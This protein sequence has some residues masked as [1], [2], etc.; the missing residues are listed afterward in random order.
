MLASG[1]TYPFVAELLKGL[2][3]DMAGK[4]F[5][6]DDREPT[7]SRISL[8]SGV[9]RKDVRRLRQAD[10]GRDDAMPDSVSFGAQLVA[11][12]VG[13]TRFQDGEGRPL[14]LARWRADGGEP[15]FE[16]L[17]ASHSKD[18]RARV[19]L[20]EWLRLGI[21]GIDDEDRIVLNSDAFIPTEGLEEKLY[22]YSH[23][24]HDHAA[25]ATDNLLGI[26][27]PRLERSVYYDE[28]SAAS[29]EDLD[30]QAR[31]LGMKMLKALNRSAMDLEARDAKS[32]AEPHRFT[33]GIY[34][35]SE[36]AKKE[37][38]P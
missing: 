31:Q 6:L 18:I 28:L 23:N 19:V 1:I 14:P 27:Q 12:W 17:V 2:F 7:D 4:E 37:P 34:F 24:L 36:P 21:V 11:N 32:L 15:S 3:V 30:R 25:A 10:P 5:R 26:R 22:F 16:E 9:H 13:E 29:I 33:C 8:L 38:S 35:Y 20:D